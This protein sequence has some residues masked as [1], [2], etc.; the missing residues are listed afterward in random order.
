M[1]KIVESNR[2]IYVPSEFAKKSLIYLQEVGTSKTLSNN[3]N[4]RDKLDSL[5]FFIVIDGNGSITYRNNT[6]KLS[7]GSCVF[8][9]C[10]YKYSHTSDNW[11][12]KWVHFNGSNSKDIYN[13]YLDRNGLNVFNTNELKKYESLIDDIQLVSNS[14]DY[15]KDMSI[16]EKLISLLSLIMS[17]TI[18]EKDSNKKYIYDIK[19]IKNYIDD[20]YLSPIS[21]DLLSKR[22]YINKFYLTRLFKQAYGTTINNYIINKKI[23]KA[24]ELL[25][26]SDLTI[27]NIA[28]ECGINDNNYFSRLFK[29]VEGISPK[30]YRTKW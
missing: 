9:D 22:F 7:K 1:N 6:Y 21:L 30:E 20:N 19:N 2:N 18:Y 27:E 3:T 23:T 8:I 12:I 28:I 5:L 24:K 14:S 11:T 29:Q 26:F 13:K 10:N 15:L 25:R 16:Y 4:S 17:E